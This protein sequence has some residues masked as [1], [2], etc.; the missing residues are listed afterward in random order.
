MDLSVLGYSLP[1]KINPLEN[2]GYYLKSEND[3][4]SSIALEFFRVRRNT[5]FMF[6]L[7]SF[8][9]YPKTFLKKNVE[10]FQGYNLDDF[11]L[12][13]HLRMPFRLY[14]LSFFLFFR[15]LL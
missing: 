13:F 9:S 7:K 8:E 14:F 1:C 2:L 5:D 15:T 11:M 12:M 10:E 6:S 4:K 3:Y